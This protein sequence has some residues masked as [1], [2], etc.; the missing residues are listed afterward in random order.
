VKGGR[1]VFS[2]LPAAWIA[3][4]Y[5]FSKKKEYYASMLTSVAVASVALSVFALVLIMSIMLGFND[6]LSKRLVG[7]NA[8]ITVNKL[9]AN[10][11]ALSRDKITNMLGRIRVVDVAPFVDGEVIAQSTTTGEV[12]AQGAKLRGVDPKNIGSLKRFFSYGKKN[13]FKVRNGLSPA[14]VGSDIVSQLVVHPAFHD[15]IQIIAPMS[16]ISPNGEFVPDEKTFAVTGIFKAGVYDYDSKYILTDISSAKRLLGQQAREGWHIQLADTTDIPDAM[17]M[18]NRRLPEGWKP[19]SWNER[20]RKLFSALKLER[21]ATISILL[22]ALMI[23]SLSIA[24][25]IFL[26]TSSKRKDIAIFSSMGMVRSKIISIF[27]YNAFY[28]GAV[29]ALIGCVASTLVCIVLKIWPMHLPDSY[30]L[31][32]LPVKVD[33]I[34]TIL[35]SSF[36]GFVAILAS[37]YPVMKATSLSVVDVLRYE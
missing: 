18:L 2:S 22:M 12:V 25:V 27:I 23:A 7:F 19:L 34:R 21:L 33:I 1:I 5:F 31:N 17:L 14:V 26:I 9:K 10:S 8:H 28:I 30:Y 29:G 32:F 35:L 15:T 16:N 4:R 37:I 6:E 11:T 3:W 36:G 20:N 13:I 24:G